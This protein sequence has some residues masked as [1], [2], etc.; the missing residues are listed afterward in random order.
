MAL[1]EEDLDRDPLAQFARWFADARAGGVFEPEAVA[2]ATASA[3]GTPSARMVLLKGHDARGL[4]FFTNYLSRKGRE[5]EENPRAAL[6]F[7]WKELG[8]QVRVEGAVARVAREE[9]EAYA[10]TRGRKSRLSALASPQSEVVASREEL[11]ARV[12][13]VES[14]H[15]GADVGVADW[16]GGY[17]L[18]PSAWEFW[19]H[20]EDRLHD[21]LRYRA[22]ERGWFIERL[23]P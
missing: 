23:A 5:L 7:H 21:R 2:L 19:Q 15:A 9:T 3:N 6:L 14:E 13:A 12:R 10:R 8:R 1:R 17:R 20:G 16:W 18:A 11:D 4:V 22:G